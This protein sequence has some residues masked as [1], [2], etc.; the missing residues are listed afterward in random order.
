MNAVFDDSSG[1]LL[2]LRVKQIKMEAQGI[3]SFEL[4]SLNGAPL[5]LHGGFTH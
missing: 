5:P 2:E 3:N 4:V 1:T